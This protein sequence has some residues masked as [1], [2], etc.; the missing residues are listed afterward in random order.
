MQSSAAPAPLGPSAGLCRLAAR[1][2]WLLI[3]SALGLACGAT[4]TPKERP[5]PA[6]VVRTPP[7]SA[8]PTGPALL[9]SHLVAQLDDEDAAPHFARGSAGAALVWSA[10]GRWRARALAPDG[11]PLG[12]DVIDVAPSAKHVPYAALRAMGDGYVL[13]W[14]EAV[15][16]NHAVKVL[17]LDAKGQ[18]RGEAA[19]ITQS[20]DE[21]SF[22][23]LLPNA[24]GAL[25]LWEVIRDERSDVIVAATDGTRALT[26][27][28]AI[29]EGAAGW[30]AIATES[31][32]ALV[33]VAG[34]KDEDGGRKLGRVIFTE[35]D[36]KGQAQAPHVVSAEPSAQIDVRIVRN[37]GRYLIAWTDE[38]AIDANVFLAAVEPGGKVVVLPRR[39]MA[40]VGEQALVGIVA[41]AKGGR[42]LLAWEDLLKGGSSERLIHLATVDQSAALGADRA[43]LVF[44]ADGP[45]D[46]A[47]DGDGF[48]AVTLAPAVLAGGGEQEKDPPIW[49]AFIRFGP[50]LSIRASEPVRSAIFASNENVPYTTRGLSC[51]DTA[52]G[53]GAGAAAQC[54]TLAGGEGVPAPLAIVSLPVRASPW[55]APARRGDED[56]VPRM[57]GLTALFDGEHISKVA[58]ADLGQGKGSLV[59]WVTYFL[60]GA[61]GDGAPKKGKGEDPFA[62]TLGVRPI[63]ADGVPGKTQILSRRA[64]SIG[65]V[66]MATA[67]ARAPDKDAKGPGKPAETAIAWV[68]RE[69]GESQVYL[70]KVGA[71][72]AKIAQKKLTIVVRKKKEGIVNEVS[73]VAIAYDGDD[74]WIVAWSDTRDGN[75]EIYV[76]RVDRDLK[77]VIPDRRITDAPGD[78]AEVQIVARPSSKDVFLVW[79]DARQSVEDGNGDMHLARLDAKTLEKRGPESRIFASEGHSR[80]PTLISSPAGLVAAWIEEPSGDSGRDPRQGSPGQPAGGKRAG[81]GGDAGVRVALFDEKGVVI[82]APTLI[83]GEGGAVTSV[84]VACDKRCRGV[85]SSAAGETL[86]LGAFE[87]TPG[88]G[89]GPLKTL[90]SLSGGVTQDV[91][92]VF[93]GAAADSLFFADDAVGGS[94]RVRWMTIAW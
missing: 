52:S 58:A 51:W 34:G 63:G 64:Q 72:G 9:P 17:S 25:V 40:P 16:K 47:A 61:T 22:L 37:G 11:A 6:R 5:R 70:T 8:G 68:A 65:G 75:A 66:A 39:A 27:P 24:K 60:D 33:T 35:V 31:G 46:L 59:A 73:D 53:Q 29:A 69:K 56:K 23:D 42:A 15:A 55:Q 45:P 20:T 93:A 54:I 28:R 21:I 4:P 82:G 86:V 7:T 87:L 91:S 85:L 18:A 78:S 43:T 36:A 50:D 94:G 92:P 90:G 19:L 30:E 88:A 76:A 12:A 13:V 14:A 83:R 57:T 84:T 71:D 1:S 41:P 67:P 26:A 89:A 3:V 77:K 32:A 62:A 2:S 74:G 38:R 48:A 49:P 79:S 80:T 81:E 10:K 44:A